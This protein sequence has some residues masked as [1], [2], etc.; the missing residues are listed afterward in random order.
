VVRAITT[1]P[2]SAF[3][4]VQRN[5]GDRPNRLIHQRPELRRRRSGDPQDADRSL[6]RDVVGVEAGAPDRGSRSLH[7]HLPGRSCPRPT[8]VMRAVS[9]DRSGRG[10]GA[11]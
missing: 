6:L 7:A 8:L 11:V 1:V 5:R 4:E 2:A 3:S 10:S 9:Q